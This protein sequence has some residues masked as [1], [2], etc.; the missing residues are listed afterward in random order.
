ML[1]IRRRAG[2]SILV[3]NEVEIQVLDVSASHVKLGILAPRPVSVL[4]K[5]VLLVSEQNRAAS[6]TSGSEVQKLAV[7]LNKSSSTAHSNR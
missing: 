2:Q 3:G 4:R 6:K 7:A 1:V 5:E